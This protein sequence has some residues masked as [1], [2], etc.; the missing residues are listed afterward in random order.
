MSSNLISWKIRVL[1][2][3]KREKKQ[4]SHPL[5]RD[6]SSLA[7]LEIGSTEAEQGRKQRDHS[8]I[9]QGKEAY[10][11]LCRMKHSFW[12]GQLAGQFTTGRT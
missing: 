10:C 7:S 11:L 2:K 3:K 6:T 9:S 1:A 5:L 4:L 8:D 12:Q